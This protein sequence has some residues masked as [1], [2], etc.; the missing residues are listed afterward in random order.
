MSDSFQE[1]TD[2]VGYPDEYSYSYEPLPSDEPDSLEIDRWLS[3]ADIS[4]LA[5]LFGFGLSQSTV[6]QINQ[7]R[8]R[9]N[10]SGMVGRDYFEDNEIQAILEAFDLPRTSNLPEDLDNRMDQLK[11]KL[12]QMRSDPDHPYIPRT[13]PNASPIVA[14]LT[15]SPSPQKL[16]P[17]ATTPLPG[18]NQPL[19]SLSHPRSYSSDPGHL[20]PVKGRISTPS[21]GHSTPSYSHSTPSYSYSGNGHTEEF[22]SDEIRAIS[23]RLGLPSYGNRDTLIKNI[24]AYLTSSRGHL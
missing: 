22:S 10:F 7:I 9:L 15:M 1:T 3:P 17:I 19:V 11:R 24:R 18:S 20:I 16:T 12:Y 8:N 6:D 2:V 14:Q 13:S 21:Y 23:K 4:R 5:Q